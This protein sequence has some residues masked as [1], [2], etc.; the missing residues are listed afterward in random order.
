MK[1]EF[2]E[3]TYDFLDDN[4]QVD[5]SLEYE[6]IIKFYVIEGYEL[7]KTLSILYHY[8]KIFDTI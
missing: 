1:N 8:F 2:K 4:Q 6:F 7:K 5:F 3:N